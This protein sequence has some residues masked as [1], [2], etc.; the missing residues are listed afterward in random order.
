MIIFNKSYKRS[1]ISVSRIRHRNRQVAQDLPAF[2]IA[3]WINL[4]RVCIKKRLLK[5]QCYLAHFCAQAF[6]FLRRDKSR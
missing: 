2:K 4:S 5:I 3:S 6:S 1:H